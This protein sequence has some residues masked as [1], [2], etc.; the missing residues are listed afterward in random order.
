LGAERTLRGIGQKI[1]ANDPPATLAAWDFR[2]AKLTA[3]S[4]FEV[5]NF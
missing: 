3:A 4:R 5:T 1:D 2:N